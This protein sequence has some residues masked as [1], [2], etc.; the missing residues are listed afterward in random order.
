MIF[1][2]ITYFLSIQHIQK[3]LEYS[4]YDV[5]KTN[6]AQNVATSLCES[7]EA[8]LHHLLIRCV[9]RFYVVCILYSNRRILFHRSRC[10]LTC[11]LHVHIHQSNYCLS[12]DYLTIRSFSLSLSLSLSLSRWLWIYS[13][14][15][16]GA[17]KPLH[18]QVLVPHRSWGFLVSFYACMKSHLFSRPFDGD[19]IYSIVTD[20]SV[21]SSFLSMPNIE[22]L[23]GG[24]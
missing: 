8:Y 21:H 15:N 11:M 23:R 6:S 4:K 24:F 2:T 14:S 1:T 12:I 7:A 17:P 5:I 18:H 22:G 3:A 13:F 19:G 16:Y 9:D 20:N 10:I